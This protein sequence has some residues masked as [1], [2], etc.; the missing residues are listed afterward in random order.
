MP[1]FVGLPRPGRRGAAVAFDIDGEQIRAIYLIANPEKLAQLSGGARFEGDPPLRSKF[2]TP[3]RRK[4]CGTVSQIRADR[5]LLSMDMKLA[6]IRL[7][8]N[9]VRALARFYFGDHWFQRRLESKTTLNWKPLPELWQS[10]A[11]E[12]WISSMPAP[13]CLAANRS[14]YR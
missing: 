1:G 11:N 6:S 10:A 9:D 3:S 13:P 7:V 8:T 4:F 2:D 12:L 5:G 14:A